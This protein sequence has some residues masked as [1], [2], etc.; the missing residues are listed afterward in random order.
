MTLVDS[1]GASEISGLGRSVSTNGKIRQTG[2]FELS[3]HARLI[4]EQGQL[5]VQGSSQSGMIV[6]GGP[7]PLGYYKDPE[8]TART[9]REVD[10]QRFAVT[11]DW[12][13]YTADGDLVFVGRGSGCINSAGEKIFPEEVEEAIKLH[14]GVAD[15]AVFGV[16]DGQFGQK[17]AA[18]VEPDDGRRLVPSEIMDHVRLHLAGFKVPRH[19]WFVDSLERTP[20]GKLDYQRLRSMTEDLLADA[21]PADDGVAGA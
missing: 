10:G 14:P 1:F 5:V 3:E 11:G 19:V 6:V 13:K 9:F 17:V 15:A 20:A 16:A 2:A 8:R 21:Y 18:V 12:A 4:D 7:L